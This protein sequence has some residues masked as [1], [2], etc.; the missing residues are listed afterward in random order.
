MPNLTAPK[1]L[2]LDTPATR[3]FFL[4]TRCRAA[5]L[6]D[7]EAGWVAGMMQATGVDYLPLA[8]WHL[9]VETLIDDIVNEE[10]MLIDAGLDPDDPQML[11]AYAQSTGMVIQ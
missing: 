9:A 4:T 11:S 5:N 10:Q 2:I 6:T 7:W 1:P 8:Q 3:A